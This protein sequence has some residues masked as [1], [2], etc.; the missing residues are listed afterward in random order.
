MR[1][2]AQDFVAGSMTMGIV[3][4]FKAVDVDH[5]ADEIA[6]VAPRTCELLRHSNLQ[7]SPVVPTGKHIGE[8]AANTAH[9]D[10]LAFLVDDV[11]QGERSD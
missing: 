11:F 10:E 5:Q 4:L 3:Y 6:T 2:L 1:E 9:W 8:A 7:V